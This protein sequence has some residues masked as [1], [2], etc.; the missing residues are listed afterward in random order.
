M[1]A[2]G[3]GSNKK[4]SKKS[5]AQNLLTQMGYPKVESVSKPVVETQDSI[6]DTNKDR[7]VSLFIASFVSLTSQYHIDLFN[8]F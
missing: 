4:L 6:Q 1:K 3:T 2:T 7:K 5:A 8:F